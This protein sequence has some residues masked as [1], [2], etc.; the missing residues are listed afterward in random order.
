MSSTMFLIPMPKLMI[1]QQHY[2]QWLIFIHIS[3]LF[4]AINQ[5]QS[6][7]YHFMHILVWILSTIFLNLM[8][9]QPNYYQCW[10][11][12]LSTNFLGLS[13]KCNQNWP[14]LLLSFIPCLEVVL[15]CFLTRMPDILHYPPF[16]ILKCCHPKVIDR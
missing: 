1:N 14:S 16:S 15:K 12:I 3:Y 5:V 10:L 4:W 8:I 9:N 2:C 11:S 6:S 7:N 13:A